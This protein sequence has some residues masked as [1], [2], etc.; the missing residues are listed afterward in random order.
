MNL[1]SEGEE[2]KKR[3]RNDG[4]VQIYADNLIP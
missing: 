4:P 2:R 3:K 1:G